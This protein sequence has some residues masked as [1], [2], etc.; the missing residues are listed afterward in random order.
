M[1]EVLCKFGAAFHQIVLHYYALNADNY[2]QTPH[3]GSKSVW[4]VSKRQKDM[5][6]FASTDLCNILSAEI[7]TVNSKSRKKTKKKR[8]CFEGKERSQHILV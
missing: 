6:K 4:G 3:K 7:L 1:V 8:C 2:C 5:R